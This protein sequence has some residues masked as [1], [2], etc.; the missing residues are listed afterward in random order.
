MVPHAKVGVVKYENQSVDLFL[1]HSSSFH[2]PIFI[3]R[4]FNFS[5]HS[6]ESN[7]KV[8]PLILQDNTNM[9]NLN[10]ESDSMESSFSSRDTFHPLSFATH[11]PLYLDSLNQSSPPVIAP[12][13]FDS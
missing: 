12:N 10:L 5:H 11:V 8:D 3:K 9:Y 6:I 7:V 2:E 4:K 13:N 1:L